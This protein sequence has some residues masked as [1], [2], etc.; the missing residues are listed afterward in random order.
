MRGATALHEAVELPHLKEEA[1]ELK[2]LMSDDD[3]VDIE[4]E[5]EANNAPAGENFQHCQIVKSK[6]LAPQGWMMGH[7][8]VW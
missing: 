7:R 4:G 3:D 5:P 1:G 2:L 8:H 6:S